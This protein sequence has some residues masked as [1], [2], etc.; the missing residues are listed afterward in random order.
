MSEKLTIE[1]LAPYVPY[2]LKAISGNGFKFEIS[3]I[4]NTH[5]FYKTDNDF[6][7]NIDCID[8]CKPIMRP[9]SDIVKKIKHNNE[10]LIPSEEL[11]ERKIMDHDLDIILSVSFETLAELLP[12]SYSLFEFLFKYHFDVFG[13][14]E[15]G[16]A[17]DDINT[18]NL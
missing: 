2:G 11:I 3:Q 4:S 14:I 10:I 8:D 6:V 17:I 16:L 18:P 9:I 7:S 13:L 5:V 1:H 12:R 15:K